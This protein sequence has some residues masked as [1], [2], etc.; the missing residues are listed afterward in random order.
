MDSIIAWVGGKRLLRK[1][2][3]TMIPKDIGG[4]IE[5]F[6]GAG[7]VLLLKEKWAR[8]EVY[9]DLDSRLTN[10]FRASKDSPES[11]T[12]I[13]N[14]LNCIKPHFYKIKFRATPIGGWGVKIKKKTS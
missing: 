4:Y 7:W 10:L 5:P 6:G 14:N 1:K 9:N 13:T 8:L 12:C 2:I 3:E 11:V